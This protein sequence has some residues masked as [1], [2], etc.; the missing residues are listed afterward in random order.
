MSNGFVSRALRYSLG[1]LLVPSLVLGT[2]LSSRERA[3][4]TEAAFPTT[5]DLCM[6]FRPYGVGYIIYMLHT[7]EDNGTALITC[8]V[9][10][11]PTECYRYMLQGWDHGRRWE[12]PFFV[13]RVWCLI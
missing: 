3:D 2:R 8:D 1:L 11:S 12:G 6:W 5:L 4:A 10:Y 13:T 9:A 7:T